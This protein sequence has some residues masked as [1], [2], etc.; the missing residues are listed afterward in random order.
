M[1]IYNMKKFE[2]VS[3]RLCSIMEINGNK[4]EIVSHKLHTFLNY[5]CKICSHFDIALKKNIFFFVSSF[6]MMRKSG[7]Q[8]ARI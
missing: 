8:N 6:L 4:F 3:T 5:C 7:K 2:L 1:D